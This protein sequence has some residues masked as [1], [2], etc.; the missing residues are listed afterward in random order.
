[1]SGRSLDDGTVL[2]LHHAH[3]RAARGGMGAGARLHVSDPKFSRF[4]AAAPRECCGFGDFWSRR[5]RLEGADSDRRARSN[6]KARAFGPAVRA[7]SNGSIARDHRL[8]SS[9]TGI[10]TELII[11]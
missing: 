10:G 1:M 2:I 3:E 8:D 7:W 6:T 4:A 11:M 5:G 9:P